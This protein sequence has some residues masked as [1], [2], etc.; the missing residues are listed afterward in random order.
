MAQY[1]N[2]DRDL[3]ITRKFGYLHARVLLDLQSE[4]VSLE[5]ELRGMDEYDAKNNAAALRSRDVNE[6]RREGM[7]RIS[8]LQKIN[9]RLADYRG[10][11][12]I[13]AGALVNKIR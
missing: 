10:Y 13:P 8:L 9:S 5:E 12:Y 11:F 2:S 3:L 6:H 1:L 7:T 4:I